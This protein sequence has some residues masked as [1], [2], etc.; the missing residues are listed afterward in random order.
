MSSMFPMFTRRPVNFFPSFSFMRGPVTRQMAPALTINPQQAMQQQIFNRIRQQEALQKEMENGGED[1]SESQPLKRKRRSREANSN[2]VYTH[3]NERS[4]ATDTHH[5][6]IH[7]IQIVQGQVRKRQAG[8]QSMFT[9]GNRLTQQGHAS[10]SIQIC[11]AV[12]PSDGYQ[13]TFNINGRSDIHQW[14]YIPVK[15]IYQR[16]PSYGVYTSYPVV[17][18]EAE[19]EMDIY[20][21]AR[22]QN[23]NKVLQIGKPA[24]WSHCSTTSG[25]GKV[26][27]TSR[28]IN[29]IGTYKEYAIVDH[30]LAISVSTAYVAIKS[31]ETGTTEVFL[32]A[33][34]ECGRVCQAFCRSPGDRNLRRCPGTFRISREHP[35]VYGINFGDTVSN[36][37]TLPT[38]DDQCPTM[39]NDMIY[40]QFHCNF[41]E[42][43]PFMSS[44]PQLP[45]SGI[46]ASSKREIEIGDDKH[47]SR[48]PEE[49]TQRENTE[50]GGKYLNSSLKRR[51]LYSSK[52]KAFS[53][54]NFV[55]DENSRKFSKQVENT[56]GGGGGGGKGEIARHQQFLL[57]PHSVFKRLALQTRKIPGKGS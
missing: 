56:G 1:L 2:V 51:I 20:S 44:Q 46:F 27:V 13:N 22:Y 57:F 28:G 31:P 53:D 52:L 49:E 16:P 29:Y 17:N 15:I 14:V 23:V 10:Q 25:A 38:A 4:R 41:R 43:W 40:V 30:R 45:E 8:N 54:D 48:R 6:A 37:W 21:P 35:K 34:D 55:F 36:L 12:P 32:S 11:P 3:E 5:T 26:Y 33:Y 39:T 50:N 47:V 9:P 19:E 42:T 24:S 18:G 7:N